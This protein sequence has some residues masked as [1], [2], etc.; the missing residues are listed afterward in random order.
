METIKIDLSK[1]IK[2]LYCHSIKIVINNPKQ[3]GIFETGEC[4]CLDCGMRWR[5]ERKLDG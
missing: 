1:A 3:D 4:E 2:C 5:H